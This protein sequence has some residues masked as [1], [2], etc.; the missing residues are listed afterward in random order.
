MIG[1]SGLVTRATASIMAGSRLVRGEVGGAITGLPGLTPHAYIQID[2]DACQVVISKLK[3]TRRAVRL[4]AVV[5]TD[6]QRGMQTSGS[7][8]NSLAGF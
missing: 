6:S 8:G 5:T 3:Q 1:L 7:T 4:S 2:S